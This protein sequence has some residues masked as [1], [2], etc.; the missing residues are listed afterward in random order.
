MMVCWIVFKTL[1]D[2]QQFGRKLGELAEAGDMICLDGELGTGKTTLTQAIAEGLEVPASFYVTSPSFAIFHEYPGRLPLYHMDF[3]R[4]RNSHEI[5]EMGFDE[6]FHLNGIT[7]I[8]WSE[9]GRDLLPADHLQL[10]LKYAQDGSRVVQ[11]QYS[12]Y[13]Q[14][15]ID[16][17][18]DC[19]PYCFPPEAFSNQILS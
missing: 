16:L 14:K 6:Y 15:R 3:Y 18:R 12:E 13:W 9:R 7:V 11:C 1:E 5:I 19:L 17:L 4:L 8:E 2:T 10:L